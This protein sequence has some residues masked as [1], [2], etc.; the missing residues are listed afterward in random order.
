MK[1]Y[2]VIVVGTGSANIVLDEALEKGL[3][4]AQ[5]E[6]GKFGGTCLTRGCIPTKVLATVADHIR[7]HELYSKI[8]LEGE[9]PRA[10]FDRISERVWQKIDES[11]EIL[12]IYQAEENLDVYQGEAF[13]TGE[14]VLQVRSKDGSLSEEM[15]ADR[16][17]L[18]VGR[19]SKIRPFPGLMETGFLTS[20]SFFG[21]SYPKK[22]YDSLLIL[23][24]GPIGCEFA[25]IF[26]ALGTKVT[27]VQHNVRL[28]P[29]EDEA[30]SE[31]LLQVFRHLGIEVIRNQETVLL[32]KENGEKVL[33]IEDRTTGERREL[34]AGELL[35]AAGTVPN[36]DLLHAM[37]G[38]L[39]MDERGCLITDE[40]L[41]TAVKGVYAFGDCIPGP[42]F[43]H[44]ANYDAEFLADTLYRGRSRKRT[45]DA[46]PMVTFTWPRVSHV[47]LTEA[48]ARKAGYDILTGTQ[49][50]SDTAKGFALGYDEGDPLTGFV[51]LVM[52]KKTGKLLGAH[53]IAP[54]ADILLQP[55]VLMLGLP[56]EKLS[57]VDG[58]DEIM[59]PHPSLSE[60]TMWTRYYMPGSSEE[61][62]EE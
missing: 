35:L 41:E 34:R 58:L 48:Q 61:T 5:I 15:T 23:G 42:E 60:L 51:K 44:R 3:R 11:K 8:G 53:I 24:G 18:G 26:S 13:F 43:R 14:K 9:A 27:L 2:D 29:K 22:V 31:K 10:N 32:R 57:L 55:F 21:S 20:E 39:P 36:T 16:I 49:P 4:C 56:P 12:E 62:K 38:G 40:N 30:V 33:T 52:E 59:P 25:H 37:Q 1:T 46:T 6:K 19:R 45:I 47:G 54:E 28:L 7:E 50:V 17:F